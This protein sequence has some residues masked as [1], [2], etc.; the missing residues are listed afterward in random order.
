MNISKTIL[1]ITDVLTVGG[2]EVLLKNAIP[3]LKE[4]RHIIVYLN[5]KNEF[6][7]DFPGTPIYCLKHTGKFSILSS[8]IRLRRIIK[9]NK[10]NIIHSHLLWSGFIA[11]LAK[12]K[13]VRLISSI[14]SQLSKDAFEKNRLSLWMEKLTA[15]RQ[16]VV[17]GV[18][19]YV[20]DDYLKFIPFKGRIHLLYNFIPDYFYN[21]HQF[22]FNQNK[23]TTPIRCIAV[24]TLKDVKNYQYILE[25]F[26]K[27][28]PDSFELDIIGEGQ[29]RN[30][31]QEFINKH[32]LPIRLLGIKNGLHKIMPDYQLFIQAS[33]YEGFGLAIA[34]AV[35]SGLFP[36]LS[37][38]PVHREI[39]IG[40]ALYFDLANPSSLSDLLLSIKNNSIDADNVTA[41]REHIKKITAPDNYLQQLRVIYNA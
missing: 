17:I 7:D 3:A 34:E 15:Y 35:A 18:S 8:V 19:Q 2:T 24:G 23:T 21:K 38:I 25:A 31:L 14:H 37:N 9:E 1:H 11:R 20:I 4:Y 12:P 26:A 33:K 40:R 29:L 41:L 39:S 13:G 28:P 16:D 32:Q 27:L 36:V 5:G 30:A 10:V 6:K 22:D